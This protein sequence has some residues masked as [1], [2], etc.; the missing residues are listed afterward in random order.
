MTL[1]KHVLREFDN[2]WDSGAPS[3]LWIWLVI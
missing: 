2:V 3:D 1:L